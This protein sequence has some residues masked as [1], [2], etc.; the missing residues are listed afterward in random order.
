VLEY[1][2][3]SVIPPRHFI[4]HNSEIL[5][6]ASKKKGVLSQVVLRL[7]IVPVLNRA[8]EA[9]IIACLRPLIAFLR[10]GVVSFA[11]LNLALELIIDIRM[12]KGGSDIES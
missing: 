12:V 8:T 1:L 7:P 5:N 3:Y 2:Q 6:P 4:R 11:N 10:I 9:G